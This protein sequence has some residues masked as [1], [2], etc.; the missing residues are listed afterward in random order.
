MVGSIYI[1]HHFSFNGS[2]GKIIQL[3]GGIY[4]TFSTPAYNVD[5]G[6]FIGMPYPDCEGKWFRIEE[7]PIDPSTHKYCRL[8]EIGD[9]SIQEAAPLPIRHESTDLPVRMLSLRPTIGC[10]YHLHQKGALED[11]KIVSTP[12]W[13]EG[14]Y[15]KCL[16]RELNRFDVG[17]D[18]EVVDIDIDLQYMYW[19]KVVKV[20]SESGS[21]NTN[22][23][24][25]K[26]TNMN[27]QVYT[28]HVVRTLTV[29]AGEGVSIGIAK[30]EIVFTTSRPIIASSA[31]NAKNVILALAA[32]QD[33][34]LDLENPAELL[35]VM[36]VQAS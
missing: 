7:I 25:E 4:K 12:D 30:S 11:L 24:R 13:K 20:E 28:G 15:C 8:L 3:K 10:I 29:P 33:S 22:N 34:N 14:T 1:V 21:G 19:R 35:E 16:R 26:E 9:P 6:G 17:C 31:Q 27:G 23:S 5:G 2:P 18:Y 36:V 32:R